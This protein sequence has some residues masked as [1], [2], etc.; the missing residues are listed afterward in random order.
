M[1]EELS[2]LVPFLKATPEIV[3]QLT[4][5]LLPA[6]LTWKF[7]ANEF[8]V[9]EHLCHLRDLEREGYAARIEKLLAEVDPFLPDFDGDQVAS[10]RDYNRQDAAGALRDFALARQANVTLLE[11]SSPAQLSRGGMFEGVGTITLGGLPHMMRE[12]DEAHRAELRELRGRLLEQRAT[13]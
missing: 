4:D 12:H 7:S 13:R 11:Q 1:T 9:V 8:S 6:E 3:R 10:E 2:K 5:G